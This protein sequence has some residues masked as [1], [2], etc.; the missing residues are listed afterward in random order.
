[1]LFINVPRYLLAIKENISEKSDYVAHIKANVLN[2]DLVIWDEVGSKGLTQFEHESILSL[3]N[4]RVC[5][6]KANIYT[7]NLTT[8]ELHD[9]VGDRLYSRIVVMSED[10][11]LRGL[12]KRRI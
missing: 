12:D 10:I 4:S 8:D 9:A 5:E 2:A 11:E 7:S 1:M 3:I 6:N